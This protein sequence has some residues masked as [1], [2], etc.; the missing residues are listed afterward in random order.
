MA[1]DIQ[2]VSIL[3]GALFS[4]TICGLVFILGL[5]PTDSSTG[6]LLSIEPALLPL[7]VLAIV[8]AMIL[9]PA[10]AAFVETR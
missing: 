1:G 4:V 10:D 8:L 5:Y 2:T 7:V 6:E 3:R 9:I